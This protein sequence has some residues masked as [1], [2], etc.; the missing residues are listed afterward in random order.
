MKKICLLFSLFVCLPFVLFACGGNEEILN[1]YKI[2]AN[3]DDENMSLACTQQVLYA[4]NSENAL[5]EVC[6][7]VYAN[8]FDEGQKAVPT[9]Y[10]NKAYPNGDSY[11]NITFESVKIENEVAEHSLSE[12]KNILTVKLQ[13]TLYPSETVTIDMAYTVNLANIHH[14]LGY[15][16]NSINFGNFFPI[17]CVYENGF[18]KNAFST[19][20]DPFYSDVSNFEV[21]ISYPSKYTIATSGNNETLVQ[22]KSKVTKCV[23][24]KVRDFCFVLS[25]KFEVLSSEV[26][27]VKVSYYFYD[28]PNAQQHLEISLKA[29][30]T[31]AELFGKY[32]YKTLNVVKTNFCFGGMEYPNL[33]YIS[34]DVQDDE[35]YN[36]CIVHEIAHQWWY[37]LVGNNEFE[38]AWVDEGL[39][40]FSTAL[41]FEA[42]AEY[43]FEYDTVL[44]NARDTYNNFVNIYTKITGKCDQSMSRTLAEFE[45]EPEY[46]NCTYTKGMLLF[47]S[48]RDTLGRRKFSKCL[49]EYF[50]DYAYKNSSPEKMIK[51]FSQTSGV[52]LESYF[53]S[54]LNGTVVIG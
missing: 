23:A 48:L 39:T 11:G 27:D 54:W 36:Y 6:F 22:S 49:K 9:S 16:N 52:N 10:E 7:F 21:E 42:N 53:A 1:S 31:F 13:N 46:V 4:N 38:D 12:N 47:A 25:D 41:F 19:S 33:V 14:R 15:G 3:F 17:A 35:V 29:L 24:S 32:P 51:S 30:T 40:E 5:D 18:V 26:G 37:G 44:A 34:D 8:A 43:N 20:G 2:V 28:D 45:T 50:K